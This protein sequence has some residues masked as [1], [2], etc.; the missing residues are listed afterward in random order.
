MDDVVHRDS[1]ETKFE[2]W[3]RVILYKNHTMAKLF[4][5]GWGV[6]MWT[7]S[8]ASPPLNSSVV[9]SFRM[10]STYVCISVR[11]CGFCKQFS[12][13]HTRVVQRASNV[14]ALWLFALCVF[15]SPNPQIDCHFPS[16]DFFFAH[17][18]KRVQFDSL[19][20]PT[21]T[22]L[23]SLVLELRQI[24]KRSKGFEYIFLFA[25]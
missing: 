22:A 23:D 13:Q 19:P 4:V 24:F 21:S 1:Q 7:S 15:A 14:D 6:L 12:C 11:I 18:T 8:F 5:D 10:S 20:T 2:L 17:V 9:S 3:L 16:D 25:V